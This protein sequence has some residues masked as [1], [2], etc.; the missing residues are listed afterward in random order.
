MKTAGDEGAIENTQPGT[1]AES[2]SDAAAADTDTDDNPPTGA[3]PESETESAFCPISMVSGEEILPLKDFALPGPMAFTWKRL[4]RTG[5]SNDT[6][7][8]HGWTHSASEHLYLE[9]KQVVLSD[10]EGRQLRFARPELHQ[11]SKLINEGLNLDFVGKNRFILRLDGQNDKV[12]TR[13]GDGNHFRL[14]KICHTAY[15]PSNRDFYGSQNSEKGFCIDLHYNAQNRLTRL[16]GNWGKG[17]K[18]K[19]NNEGRIVSVELFNDQQTLRKIVAEYDYNEH[20]DLM[21]SRDSAGKGEKYRYENHILMQRTLVTGFSYHYKWDRLDNKARCIHGWGDNGIYDYHFKWDPKNNTSQF[22]D[23]LGNTTSFIYNEFG[24]ITQKIDPEGGVHHYEYHRGHKT[25]YTDPQDHSHYYYF[26]KQNQ[27]AGTRDAL[28]N[29]DTISYFN[30]NPTEFSDKNGV[31]WKR[32]YDRQGLLITQTDP[33]GRETC[34]N[35]HANNLLSQ[36]TDPEGRTTHYTW[37]SLGEL[38]Q[39]IDFA[40][41]RQQRVH[42]SQGQI[43]ER[44]V[45]LKDQKEARTTRYSYTLTGL[46]KKVTA[47]NGDVNSY[48]YNDNAQLIQHSDPQGRVTEFE[49]ADGLSQV[50]KR[51]DSNGHVLRYQYDKER[52]LTALINQNGEKHRFIY[53]RCERLVKEIGFDGRVQ[54]YKYNKAGHLIKH[55]D[56]GSIITEYE[57]DAIGQMLSRT[58]R[59][60]SQMRSNKEERSR[61]RY[62]PSGRLIE[63]YNPHQYLSFDYDRM[64][65]LQKEHHCD[66]NE[67]NQQVSASKVD[68]QYANLLPGASPTSRSQITLPDGQRID[69]QY[70]NDQKQQL[71]SIQFNGQSI[72]EYHRD[73]LGR[74]VERRQG[75]VVTQTEYDPM[76]RLHRQQGF[77]QA[78]KEPEKQTIIQREYG[79]DQFGNLNQLKDDQIETHYIYDL[80]DQIQKV[81]ER[82]PQ[83]GSQ[84]TFSFD[85]AGNITGINELRK[86]RREGKNRPGQ[87]AG[88]RLSMQGD[89]KFTYDERGNLIREIRGKGG[90]LKTTFEYNLQN[91]LVKTTKNGQTTEYKY[92]PLGRRFEKKDTFGTTKYLWADDQLAQETRNNIKK[93]YVYEPQSFKPVAL[94][95]DDEVYHYHLDHLGT[96]RELTNN[97]GDIVWKARYRTYGSVA[98]QECEEIENNLRF[99]GQYFD[100][101]SGLHYNR[102][103]YYN[104]D[105][106]Q[107]ISQDPVGLLGGVNNYQYAPNPIGWIDPSGLCKEGASLTTLQAQQRQKPML[108]DNIGFN[109]SPTAWDKYPVTGRGRTFISE[110]PGITDIIGDFSGPSK[111][112]IDKAKK[113]AQVLQ[114]GK[115]DGYY[116]VYTAGIWEITVSGFFMCV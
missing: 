26:S 29:R 84:E 88:N 80:L 77:N 74:E 102:H 15:K 48:R 111:I 8:G 101:E 25:C 46:L 52:N 92:D 3:A 107:F 30:G 64:G 105:T 37:N 114:S 72:T 96:P 39:I 20:G 87:A 66:I 81:E 35:Y 93:T 59:H 68:I 78:R 24:L 4:Y 6:G 67:K 70:S 38:T 2:N 109:I 100:E 113:K 1:V 63:T 83:G 55:M 61:Y 82:A 79:Y 99:Q 12:F 103:R 90:K 18:L 16:M 69:Y 85:P 98:I 104:P 43:T 21:A 33:Y 44:H 23:T 9:K 19:R 60:I 110:Q 22:T 47:P 34:F 108:N 89:R 49:Y 17:L 73:I 32:Q 27:P 97:D 112:A 50:T 36:S 76:G 95:Q 42:N 65:N 13:L 51:I 58:S 14:S 28:G 10:D 57:R 86:K 94:I 40:G 106:G 45:R 54:H 115:T 71:E 11:R 91:Q 53:D 31:S 62:D 7:L 56:A 5:H 116:I 75:S 41:N